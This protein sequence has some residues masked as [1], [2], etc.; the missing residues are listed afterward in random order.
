[1]LKLHEIYKKKHTKHRALWL[2]NLYLAFK[3]GELSK[4]SNKNHEI[5]SISYHLRFHIKFPSAS[6]NLVP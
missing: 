1:M 6:I 3:L 2:P 5:L 4:K